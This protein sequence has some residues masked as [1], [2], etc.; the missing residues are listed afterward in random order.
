MKL[1]KTM[2]LGKN[3]IFKG[4][5]Y[6]M[7]ASVINKIIA[8][9]SNI[10]V[11]RLVSKYEYG[12]F[13]SANNIITLA[14]LFTGLGTINGVLQYG[15]ENRSDEEKNQFLKNCAIMGVGFDLFITICI[16]IYAESNLMP[17]QE[18][19]KYILVL[20]P[21]IILHYLFEYLGAILRSRK[22]VKKY[23][24]LLNINSIS[25]SL[26]SIIG[27]YFWGIVGLAIGRSISYIIGIVMG[28]YYNKYIICPIWTAQQLGRHEKIELFKYSFSCCIIS[29]LNRL[30]YVVDVV[31]ISYVT[32]DAIEVATYRV[33]TMIPEALEFIPQS[34]LIAVIPY[35]A[36]HNKDIEWLKVWT[37]KLYEFSVFLNLG[38]TVLLVLFSHFFITILGGREYQESL[39]VFISLS[40]NYFIMA[41]FRQNGTNI[42]STLRMTNY[43]VFISTMTCILDIVLDIILVRQLGCV[44]AAVATVISV[45]IASLL[46]F[47]YVYYLIYTKD[48]QKKLVARKS[49]PY[50]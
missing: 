23:A 1:S 31:V 41:T 18:T 46:S 6:V 20:A 37:K 28:L 17:I 21:S 29:A 33:G 35:F 10:I 27:A 39:P 7:S 26:L 25:F 14:M 3:K 11:V 48:G 38:L 15:A 24:Y 30:L 40:I 45:T 47:P 50:D 44:G 19:K 13:S 9:A 36:E 42:L 5:K 16:C 22:S 12:L 8:F 49:L 32:K 43:N 34:I 4:I 2:G